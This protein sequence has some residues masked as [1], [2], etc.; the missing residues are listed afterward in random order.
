MSAI[1][2]ATLEG[3]YALHQV[4][5]ADWPALRVPG[6]A[7]RVARG[8][9]EAFAALAPGEGWSAHFRLVGGAGDFLFVHFRPTL[10]A[11]AAVQLALRHSPLSDALRLEYDYLSVTEAGLYHATAEA[12]R[13][14]EPGSEAFRARVDEALAAERAS[15]HVRTRLYPEV[16]EGMRYVSFYPMSKRRAAGQNWYTL[17]VGERSRLM[18]EHG[19]TGRRFAGRVFQVITGSVGLDDWE[20]GVT[21][22]ARDPLEFKR[23]VTEM[24]YDQASAEYG[25]FGAFYTG[26]RF[27]PEEWPGLLGADGSAS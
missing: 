27:A 11:L 4:F 12:A 8:A 5:S 17:P 25:E 23:I 2:P 16:P 22:F 26:I 21:L 9:Q 15:P 20:W 7:A 24:R 19:M 3:W 6:A 10:D 18:R 14:G 13:A 1:A